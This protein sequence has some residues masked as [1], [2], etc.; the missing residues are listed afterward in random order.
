MDEYILETAGLVKKYR[1]STA[2]S[3]LDI[4]I[5]KGSVYGF[6]G[7][8]G[9]G[10]TTMIR[11][12][13]G[14]QEPTDGSFTLYGVKNTDKRINKCRLKLGAVVETPSVYYD[15]TAKENL[16]QQYLMLGQKPDKSIDGLLKLVGLFNT[17]NKKV[18][19]FSLGMRQ[20]LGIAT[21]LAGN[22]DFLILD[23][24]TNG[25]DPEGI[26][27]IRE[28]II[29]LN[30]ER[31]ITVLVSSHILDELARLATDFGFID[32]GKTVK[33]MNADELFKACRKRTLVEVSD[34]GALKK[35]LDKRN[36]DYKITD[37]F[38]ADI[39]DEVPVTELVCELLKE[40]CTVKS[41]K[42]HDESLESFYMKLLG[43]NNNE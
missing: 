9:A 27:E 34:I 4:H 20:R 41:L 26:I 10:K 16:V 29:K 3:G 37:D 36:A 35:V 21:A 31:G 1:G 30:K 23:E 42:E 38:H 32:G 11:L 39:Y 7:R 2:L 43:G 24:P 25:L 14:L 18:K 19:D 13:C 17:G 5:K 22:P 33:E 28:L 15:M 6:I 12:I 40:N 8:N